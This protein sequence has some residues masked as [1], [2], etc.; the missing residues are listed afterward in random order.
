MQCVLV[1]LSS[2]NESRNV[3]VYLWDLKLGDKPKGHL[4][5]QHQSHE[6]LPLPHL[7]TPHS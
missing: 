5:S 6:M 7:T 1:L 2:K 3:G 4:H